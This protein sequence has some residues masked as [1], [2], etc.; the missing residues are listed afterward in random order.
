[1]LQQYLSESARQSGC[2]ESTVSCAGARAWFTVKHP[3]S[4]PT[5]VAATLA[6]LPAVR[7]NDYTLWPGRGS[8]LRRVSLCCAAQA[9][10]GAAQP[11]TAAVPERLLH[12]MGDLPVRL[13]S[14]SPPQSIHSYFASAVALPAR[15]LFALHSM[16]YTCVPI[17]LSSASRT[18]GCRTSAA[19]SSSASSC[20]AAAPT[21][22]CEQRNCSFRAAAASD[23][24]R[25]Q[26][27][28][29]TPSPEFD[30]IASS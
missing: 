23:A 30:R 27:P 10:Y 1:M 18:F 6:P 7:S 25:L 11:E 14:R 17:S 20:W 4:I 28:S 12:C 5:V 13:R 2:F 16:G 8:S 22:A 21:C 24:N 3:P 19:V 26:C 15:F 29:Q 9:V